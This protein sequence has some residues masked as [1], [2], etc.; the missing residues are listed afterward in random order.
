MGLFTSFFGWF[1][2]GGAIAET[3]GAQQAAP[4]A[5]LVPDTTVL[6]VDKALQI[7][8]VWAC[9]ERRATTVASLPFFAY[10]VSNGQKTL[11]RGS[12]LYALLHDSP[13]ARMT[14][15]EFWRAMMMN[16]D[17]RGNAYARIDRDAKGEAYALTPMSADQVEMRILSD[18][19][20]VYLYSIGSDVAV[21]AESSVVHFKGMG[22]GT[23]GLSRLDYMRATTD[24]AANAQTTA[25]RL[26]A[27]GGKPT[28][29]LMVDQ[30]L[31]KDQRDRIRL[32][33]EELATAT[34]SRL[35]VLEANM[36]Y[37]QVSLLPEDMQLLETRQ[38][39]VE[40]ICRWFGVPPVMV[41][42]ANVT[43]WGSGVEQILD[44]FF[45]LT[46]RPAIV[47]FEQALRKRVLTANQRALYSVEFSIDALL[48]ANIK[49]RFDVYGKA[50]QNGLKTRNECRQ[51]ENDP[52]IPGGDAL[53]AQTNLVPLD[54]LGQVTPGASNGT[55]DPIAQ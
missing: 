22:N 45:K 10:E 46:I 11:A 16:H 13:N 31:N 40:E 35:F 5:Q 4:S 36:K 26:F 37:Q 55:Q 52:P 25:N 15:L 1:R 39:T 44:G 42:H 19:T 23:I 33:F 53:T 48:R 49:D 17:L 3:T 50:V 47:N 43:T 20:V 14:P 7:A 29:V 2:A 8:T 12:R 9:V 34:T 51:L 21:L 6:P 32:N 41:G 18:G 28:G 27:A 30:V 38:F 24:E 54:K